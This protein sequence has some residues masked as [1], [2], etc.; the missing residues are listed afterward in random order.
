MVG[1]VKPRLGC[2]RLQTIPVFGAPPGLGGSPR[3]LE[4]GA[5]DGAGR[6][7]RICCESRYS[8]NIVKRKHLLGEALWYKPRKQPLEPK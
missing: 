8:L 1:S 7:E 4:A 6:E 3:V 5:E 2:R